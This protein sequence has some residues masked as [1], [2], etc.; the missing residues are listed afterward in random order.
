MTAAAPPAQFSP[1]LALDTS[2]P[3]ARVALVDRDG[4]TLVGDERTSAR[5]SDSLLPLCHELFSRVALTPAGLGGIACGSGPGSF[6]GLRVGLAVAKG[7]A[8]ASDLPIVL[9]PSLTALALDLSRT[10]GAGLLFPCIDAGKGEVY[11]QRF[12]RGGEAPRAEGP[13]RRLG[14]EALAAE[15]AG[16]GGAALIAGTGA[17]RHAELFRRLLGDSAVLVGFPGPSASAIAT[18]GLARL[19]RG[20]RDDLDAV[21]PSYGRPPDITTPKRSPSS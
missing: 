17:D 5:H 8:L 3:T 4:K 9:V 19:R 6:T 1:I 15:L 2:G 12:V 16:I 10:P 18:L 21:V 7:F 11:L 13:E 20:E 14:P